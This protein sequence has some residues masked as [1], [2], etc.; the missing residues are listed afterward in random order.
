MSLL[1]YVST[2]WC[3]FVSF[4]MRTEINIGTLLFLFFKMV[5]DLHCALC[6][7]LKSMTRASSAEHKGGLCLLAF[8]SHNSFLRWL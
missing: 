3:C 5:R 4:G 2:D 7:G 1:Y 8:S 6:V